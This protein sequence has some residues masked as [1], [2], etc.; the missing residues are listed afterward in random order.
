VKVHE[1]ARELGL[2]SKELIERLETM[3]VSVRN[4]MSTLD[5]DIVAR[6]R[7]AAASPGATAPAGSAS[8]SANT[9][10][11]WPRSSVKVAK[12]LSGEN[13]SARAIGSWVSLFRTVPRMVLLS[14]WTIP[15]VCAHSGSIAAQLQRKTV[16][17]ERTLNGRG[18]NIH[19]ESKRKHVSMLTF[20]LADV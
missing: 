6:V 16:P 10:S 5:P 20:F 7:K 19:F 12:R 13:T 15:L 11:K 1:L 14:C 9:N 3:K 18:P 2:T 17:S 4:H 8:A